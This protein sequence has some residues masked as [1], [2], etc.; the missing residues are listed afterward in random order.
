LLIHRLGLILLLSACVQ[1]SPNDSSSG[2]DINAVLRAHDDE[3]LQ[4]PDVVGVSVALL[5]DNKTQCLKV[6][7]ARANPETERRLPKTIEGY[8]VITE[9]T[10]KFRPLQ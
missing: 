9:I 8:P 7:L 5:P 10:G 4:L 2:R 1:A 3:L 6:M